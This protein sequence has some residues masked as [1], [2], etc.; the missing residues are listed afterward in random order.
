M[1]LQNRIA[2]L[3]QYQQGAWLVRVLLPSP[4][5]FPPMKAPLLPHPKANTPTMGKNTT[6]AQPCSYNVNCATLPQ[7]PS[8]SPSSIS[9]THLLSSHVHTSCC[10]RTSARF[11]SSSSTLLNVLRN[12]AAVLKQRMQ[13]CS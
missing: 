8:Q 4:T 12:R 13:W 11:R 9:R 10:C 5:L 1:V 2:V 6:V 3:K 7:P